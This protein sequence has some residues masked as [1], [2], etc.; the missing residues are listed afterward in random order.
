MKDPHLHFG[1]RPGDRRPV[2]AGPLLRAVGLPDD[3]LLPQRGLG[4]FEDFYG[5]ILSVRRTP[6]SGSR[7]DGSGRSGRV[8]RSRGYWVA[9][10]IDPKTRL[11][12]GIGTRKDPLPSV[13]EGH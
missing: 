8:R 3:L 4:P 12:R 13:A 9:I 6:G 7:A 10:E 5:I 11:R 2:V 1:Q